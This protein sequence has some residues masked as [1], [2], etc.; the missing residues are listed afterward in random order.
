MDEDEISYRVLRKIQKQ[1]QNSPKLSELKHLFYKDVSEYL[2][3]L[4]DRLKEETSTQKQKILE[5]E[6]KN[7]KKIFLSIYEQREK[8]ILLAAISKA[9]GGKPSI[10]HM[11]ELEKEL[12]EKTLETINNSRTKILMKGNKSENKII[13]EK[14][15]DDIENKKKEV[16]S[17][18]TKNKNPIVRIK[19]GVPEFIGTDKKKYRLNKNDIISISPDICKILCK[20]D[21][22]EKI[23]I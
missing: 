12:F 19:N 16:S 9:R 8:K 20:R 7:T 14:K 17:N 5:E 1:E 11:K 15:N 21:I 10:E 22:S 2:N 18:K 6:I 4:K 3:S 23:E 13:E